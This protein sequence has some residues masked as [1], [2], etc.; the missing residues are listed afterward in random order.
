MRATFLYNF[1]R[2]AEWPAG[3]LT[4]GEPLVLCV[5]G[6]PA[7]ATALEQATRGRDAAGHPLLVR[8]VRVDGP[9]R[10]CHVLY[11]GAL[12]SDGPAQ[13]V[14]S[15][16]E[17]PVFSVSDFP[18]FTRMGGVAQLFVENGRMR[19]AINVTAAAQAKLR[20]NSRL[21]NVAR[22]DRGDSDA[23]R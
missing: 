5:A 23:P 3:A 1:A 22:L 6:D 20:L 9:L 13:V 10:S 2:F 18:A 19:V 8:T 14:G 17:A 11:A 7:V 12:D 15:V 21:L 4:P 16:R